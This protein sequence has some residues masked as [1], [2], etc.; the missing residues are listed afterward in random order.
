MPRIAVA[1]L[2]PGHVTASPV[3][4]VSGV[5]LVQAHTELTPPLIALLQAAG[6]PSVSVTA[7]ALT[8]EE[9]ARRL[10][11]IQDRFAGHEGNPWMQALQDAVVRIQVGEGTGEPHA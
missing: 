6:V 7:G 5:V 3:T 2:Q 10:R 8:P 4:S 11:D 9:R 1:D